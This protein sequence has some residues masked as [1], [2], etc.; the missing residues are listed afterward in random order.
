MRAGVQGGSHSRAAFAE[1]HEKGFV[2][3]ENLPLGTKTGQP[4]EVEFVST[5]YHE[6]GG[7]VIQCNIRDCHRTQEDGG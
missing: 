6:S 5:L 3:Y 4:R 1:L 2:R 7:K